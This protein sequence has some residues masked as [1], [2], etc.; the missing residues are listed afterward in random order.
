M[1]GTIE[2][3]NQHIVQSLI[4]QAVSYSTTLSKQAQSYTYNIF[5]IEETL[6]LKEDVHDGGWESRRSRQAR[7]QE[8]FALR[9]TTRI[10]TLILL[11]QPPPS[12]PPL[13]PSTAGHLFQFAQISQSQ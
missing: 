2:M 13:P 1:S 10:L 8:L 9:L 11:H 6:S 5:L 7:R 12:K 3:L 4:V